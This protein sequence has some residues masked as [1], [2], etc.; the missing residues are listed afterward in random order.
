MEDFLAEVSSVVASFVEVVAALIVL[1]GAIEAIYGICT[2]F[3]RAG[4][5]IQARADIWRRFALWLILA[6][7]F[8]LAAD[9]VRTAI[10]PT[11][12]SIG[13]L[14]AIALIRTF[15]SVFLV[16]DLRDARSWGDTES[17]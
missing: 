14:G 6:L 15:L 1:G 11:W 7:E 12:T 3:F 2:R 16:R 17:S 13:Q 5:T 10:K 8:T 4:G 9:L